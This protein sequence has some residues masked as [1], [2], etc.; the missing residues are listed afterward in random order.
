MANTTKKDITL[1]QRGVPE[2]NGKIPGQ[3]SYEILTYVD[4][5]VL[6]VEVPGV[7]PDTIEMEAHSDSITITCD[8]GELTYPVEAALD[9]SKVEVSVRWGM[10]EIRFPFRQARVV[11]IKIGEK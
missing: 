4:E 3:L 10:L 6:N 9:L 2:G 5:K 11:K 8:R 1:V 7:D